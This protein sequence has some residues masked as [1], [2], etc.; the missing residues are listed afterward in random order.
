[1]G[2]R[3]KLKSEKITKRWDKNVLDY[4]HFTMTKK[5]LTTTGALQII[6]KE[7]KVPIT[8][9]SYSGTKDSFAL[10]SQRISGWRISASAIADLREKG[11]LNPK[12]RTRPD[13]LLKISDIS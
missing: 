8:R 1:M 13:I 4:T 5:L 3:S 9:F 2:T 10:T 7:L 12:N 6:A 11:N